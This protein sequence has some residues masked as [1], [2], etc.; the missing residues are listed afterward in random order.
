[1]A[2]AL[3]Y[4]KVRVDHSKIS[5]TDI[6]KLKD[7]PVTPYIEEGRENDY[8]IEPVTIEY[9]IP[10]ESRFAYETKM[11]Y[12]ELYDPV[13]LNDAQK[14]V[15]D[16]FRERDEPIDPVE[17]C[18]QFLEYFQLINDSYNNYMDIQEAV[19]REFRAVISGENIQAVKRAVYLTEMLRKIEPRLA[20][21]EVLGDYTT[22]NLNWC[23]RF[24]NKNNIQIV[25]EDKTVEYLMKLHRLKH[26]VEQ[27]AIDE[28]FEILAAIYMDQAFPYSDED[29]DDLDDLDL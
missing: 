28:R 15:M 21:L 23:I 29:D 18:N 7:L 3:K 5:F 1:M 12:I 19:S 13:P 14:R 22:Y 16:Y 6:N 9:Y 20:A 4:Q 25:L 17:V 11:L 24:C 8:Y 26:E 2:R 10:K 27:I